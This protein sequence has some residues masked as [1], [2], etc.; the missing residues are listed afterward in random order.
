MKPGDTRFSA[1]YEERSKPV[2][3]FNRKAQ[4]FYEKPVVRRTMDRVTGV[5]LIGFGLK[6]RPGRDAGGP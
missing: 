5:V 6:A 4:A 1:T 2:E 3:E